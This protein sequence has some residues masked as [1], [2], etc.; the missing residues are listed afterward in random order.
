M[1]LKKRRSKSSAGKRVGLGH[2]RQLKNTIEKTL[3][4]KLLL[5]KDHVTV[6]VAA[7]YRKPTHKIEKGKSEGGTGARKK[8]RA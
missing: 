6:K 7:R 1:E 3:G 4:K 5:K 2:T 8:G